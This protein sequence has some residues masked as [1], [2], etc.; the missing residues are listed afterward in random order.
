MSALLDAIQ[1]EREQLLAPIRD[2]LDTLDRIAQLAERLNGA[3]GG[4]CHA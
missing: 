1:A 2:K 4:S 3:G